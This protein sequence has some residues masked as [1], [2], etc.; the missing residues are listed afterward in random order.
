MYSMKNVLNYDITILSSKA[1]Y[2]DV[3]ESGTKNA[4]TIKS[5]HSNPGGLPE[6]MRFSNRTT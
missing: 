6:D 3:I 1:L 5:H 4:Q 2:T